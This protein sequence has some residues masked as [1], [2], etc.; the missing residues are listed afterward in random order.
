[1]VRRTIYTLCL[2]VF[3]VLS[4]CASLD[5]GPAD[6]RDASVDIVW[7][8]APDQPRVRFLRSL[9][10]SEDFKVTKQGR[11][12][13]DWLLGERQAEFSMLSPFAVAASQDGVVW[14]AD[15]GARILFRVDLARQKITYLREF[16]GI[17]LVAPS[18]VAID[19]AQRRVYLADA[20]LRR[21]FV[22]DLDGGHLATWGEDQTLRR[23]AG[24]A[25]DAGGRL[26]VADALDGTVCVFTSKGALAERI[27]SKV[28]S[29]GRFR[30]P[31]AVALGP[32]GEILILD[33][34]SFR[35]EVQN[36][37][38]DLLGTIGQLGDAAGYLARPKGLAVDAEG[39]VFISDSAFDNI[40]VF[41]MAGTLLMYW[42]E[43][44]RQ[45]GQFSLPAGLFVDQERRLLVADSYNRR[46]QAFQLLP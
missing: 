35:V 7:P 12:V 46:V 30:R 19:E 15:S 32:N 14:I 28:N 40:Q 3:V 27:H 38:G 8:K 21:I 36:A 45:P 4:G 22:L 2:L 24:L 31:L 11:G 41:D 20:A 1:M 10:G 13:L 9:N 5:G 16:S 42:G 39:H 33:A 6:W 44:G 37:H 18:G 34:F 26:L 23:P 43:A 25:V 17:A 29:D